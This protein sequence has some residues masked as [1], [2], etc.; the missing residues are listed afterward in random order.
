MDSLIQDLIDGAALGY[1]LFKFVN[2][3]G[4]VTGTS[5]QSRVSVEQE[6]QYQTGLSSQPK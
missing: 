3:D 1:A 2:A 6:F 5:V 4:F